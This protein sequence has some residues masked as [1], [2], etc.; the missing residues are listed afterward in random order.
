MRDFGSARRSTAVI[1][2][3]ALV[4]I[5]AAA[6]AAVAAER[7]VLGEYFTATW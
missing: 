3:T 6:G 4:V 1:G 5:G 2:L 7:T